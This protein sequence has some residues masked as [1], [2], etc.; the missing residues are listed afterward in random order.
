MNFQSISKLQRTE[1][2]FMEEL[3]IALT[4]K[5]SI[6]NEIKKNHICSL[7]LAKNNKY[8]IF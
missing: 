8:K 7:L 6:P 2:F 5:I 3:I 4:T 1:Q